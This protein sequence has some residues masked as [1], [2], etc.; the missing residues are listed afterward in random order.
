MENV[1]D[2][3]DQSNCHNGYH[4]IKVETIRHGPH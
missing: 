3:T 1:D 4:S 2:G